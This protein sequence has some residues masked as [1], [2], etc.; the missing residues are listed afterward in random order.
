MGERSHN[1]AKWLTSWDLWSVSTSWLFHTVATTFSSFLK[2]GNHLQCSAQKVMAAPWVKYHAPETGQA[3]L[4][5]F[6]FILNKS[7]PVK[8]SFLVMVYRMVYGIWPTPNQRHSKT[9]SPRCKDGSAR[10]RLRVE[11][12]GRS[13]GTAASLPWC[14]TSR[15]PNG[16][17]NVC[18]GFWDSK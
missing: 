11:L 10:H 5:L 12:W 3:S 2:H 16:Y 14:N 9:P 6:E 7:V 8:P 18:R 15:A 17:C 13:E 1:G 4:N